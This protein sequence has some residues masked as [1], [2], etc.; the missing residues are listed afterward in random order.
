MTNSPD[1]AVHRQREEQLI[2]HVDRLLDDD[3]LRIDTT[4]GRRPVPNFGRR[5]EMADQETELIRLMS[6]V[7]KPDRDLQSRMPI[8]K[9]LTVTLWRQK[10]FVLKENVGIL[11]VACVSP[12]RAL[13]EG[14]TPT[15]ID[16][17]S[18]RKLAEKLTAETGAQGI[19][20]TL[21]V[22]STAGFT[23]DAHELADRRADRTL[24]LVEPNEAGGWE[25]TGPSETQA[26]VDLFDP[27]TDADKRA[28]LRTEIEQAKNDL[29]DGAL[30][31]ERIAGATK[32]PIELVES[33]LKSFAKSTPGLTAK[34]LNGRFVVFREGSGVA[35]AAPAGGS[36]MPFLQRLKNLFGRKE[37]NEAK[38]AL[39]SER[40]AVLTQQRDAAYDEIA[41]LEKKEN[42]LREHFKT[43]NSELAKRRITGQL[44]QLRKDM[45]RRQQ[46]LGVLNQQVN[47][48]STHLHN[49]ELVAQ[50]KSAQLPESEELQTEAEEAEKILADLQV[51]TELAGA[52][53]VTGGYGM[54]DEEKALY[55]ELERES[56][57][58]KAAE[59]EPQQPE[60][61]ATEPP[62]RPEP[63]RIAQRPVPAARPAQQD[64]EPPP[65]PPQPSRRNEPE[66]G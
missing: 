49:I 53:G 36:D 7:G 26:L 61:L 39:L 29:I 45:E 62:A 35:S 6:Q 38:I 10:W 37:S 51:N 21:V 28:R 65:L 55:E 11:K 27:E 8:G 33:E 54:T 64:L 25:V 22:V 16:V 3:R 30:S 18:L 42:D 12:T 46:L 44:L 23:V 59:P 32:L 47:V 13:L 60:P 41:I 17:P 58:Q 2:E 66:A 1:P 4:L 24:I 57:A 5:I 19:P 14:Q 48:L 43:S 56:A 50:G 31:A 20:L 9:S 52:M 34:R 40:R 15:P 63:Q